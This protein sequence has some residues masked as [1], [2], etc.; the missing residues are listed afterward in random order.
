MNPVKVTLLKEFVYW[1]I[2]PTIG[3]GVFFSIFSVQIFRRKLLKK[4]KNGE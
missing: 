1:V 2:A 3:A 4:I